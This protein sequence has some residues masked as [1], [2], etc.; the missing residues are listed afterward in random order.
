LLDERIAATA[1]R[2][3]VGDALDQRAVTRP[4]FDQLYRSMNDY[5]DDAGTL[6]RV[7]AEAIEQI[8]S[9]P[10][11]IPVLVT[12]P[13]TTEHQVTIAVYA[14]P[15][16]QVRVADVPAG[17]AG[18]AGVAGGYQATLDLA[19][20][21]RRVR[22][23]VELPSGHKTVVRSVLV[24][25]VA[26]QPRVTMIND[27]ETDA[28]IA[29]MKVNRVTA[30]RSADDATSG[31]SSAQLYF[32]PSLSWPGV[33]FDAAAHVGATDWSGYDAIAFDVS[34]P[35][36]GVPSAARPPTSTRCGWRPA[37]PTSGS[38]LAQRRRVDRVVCPSAP[39][40]ATARDFTPLL[41]R[42]RQRRPGHACHLHRPRL[43]VGASR[44]TPSVRVAGLG[45]P[46]AD[47]RRLRA[48]GARPRRRRGGRCVE[49]V[50]L[51]PGLRR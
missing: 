30:T 27:F 3:G 33:T 46:A 18:L 51:P 17:V 5:A 16:A 21:V 1:T 29:R 13:E 14:E 42:R 38:S 36:P 23:D 48:G 2:L 25:P 7:R 49:L 39:P 6:A 11:G 15:G 10:V 47:A 9:L 26:P 32:P 8:E 34:N 20:G 44:T 40:G 41:P 24:Q 50:G 35:N 28:D 45:V 31:S 12:F 4:L 37:R 22:V 19:A 43:V